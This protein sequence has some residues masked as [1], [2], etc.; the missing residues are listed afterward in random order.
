MSLYDL[1]GIRLLQG[2]SNLPTMPLSATN[3]GTAPLGPDAIDIAGNMTGVEVL[4]IGAPAG[5]GLTAIVGP[6]AGACGSYRIYLDV[7][8]TPALWRLVGLS[9]TGNDALYN[10]QLQNAFQP[11]NPA[12]NGGVGAA[13]IVRIVDNNTNK[14]Q[15]AA[16]CPAG[17]ASW[18]VPSGVP[19]PYV[20]LDTN[21]AITTTGIQQNWTINPVHIVRWQIQPSLINGATSDPTKYDLTRQFVDAYGSLAGNPEVIAEYAVDLK[22]A[23][24]VDTLAST[25]GDYSG[26]STSPLVVN[27]FEDTSASNSIVTNAVVAGD[28]AGSIPG[29]TGP[30]PQRIRSV[31]MRVAT[32]SATQDRTEALDAGSPY[33][34]RYTLGTGSYARTRTLISEVSLPNQ[35]RLWFQ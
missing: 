7:L 11:V 26:L 5:S 31:R 25:L 6:G 30:Y 32:R 33:L 21:S 13:F 24:T 23:F 3:Y 27:T 10:T 15:Y 29:G 8:S 12:N 14:V 20:D 2:G 1:A 34:Y 4:S 17:A 16:T 9:P 18:T 22:F 28:V 19:T 35:A